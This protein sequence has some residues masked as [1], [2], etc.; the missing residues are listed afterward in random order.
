M[1]A[2]ITKFAQATKLQKQKNVHKKGVPVRWK[3]IEN[4]FFLAIK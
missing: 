1:A 3:K 2:F 4:F